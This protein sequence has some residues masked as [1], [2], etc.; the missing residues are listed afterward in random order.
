MFRIESIHHHIGGH[1]NVTPKNQQSTRI[2]IDSS[3]VSNTYLGWYGTVDK[4]TQVM[5]GTVIVFAICYV[6]KIGENDRTKMRIYGVWNSSRIERI[7]SFAMMMCRS[8]I[9]NLFHWLFF[10]RTIGAFLECDGAHF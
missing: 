1:P 5:V 4:S 7:A 10:R 2:G 3:E 8:S 9:P 6:G